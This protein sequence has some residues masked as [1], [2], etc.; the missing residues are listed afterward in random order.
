MSSESDE[1]DLSMNVL[2]A[3]RSEVCSLLDNMNLLQAVSISR[4]PIVLSI[5][6]LK[7]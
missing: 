2:E 6:S 4:I 7:L 3:A 1:N 5:T